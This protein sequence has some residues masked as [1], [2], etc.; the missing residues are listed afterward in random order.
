MCVGLCVPL[1]VCV[2]CFF[3]VQSKKNQKK[4][5]FSG[6]VSLSQTHTSLAKKREKKQKKSGKS[7]VNQPDGKR[8][9]RKKKVQAASSDWATFR[10][11]RGSEGG[12]QDGQRSCG[13]R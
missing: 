11:R 9:K 5:K 13:G 6:N 7:T 4:L 12:N 2:S 10:G 8:E 3:F 1:C